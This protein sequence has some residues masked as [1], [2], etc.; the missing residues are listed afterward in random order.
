VQNAWSSARLRNGWHSACKLAG[1]T[2]GVLCESDAFSFRLAAD[3]V[4]ATFVPVTSGAPEVIQKTWSVQITLP[5]HLEGVDGERLLL[6]PGVY[7]MTE[8]DDVTYAIGSAR[9]PQVR[10][11]VRA[12]MSARAA[13][14]LLVEGRWP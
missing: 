2:N 4:L 14:A 3:E 1:D 7:Q 10:L 5:L 11:R 6:S 12:V 9:Q 8:L 13:G